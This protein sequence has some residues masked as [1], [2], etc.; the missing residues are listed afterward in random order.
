MKE[1]RVIVSNKTL[2]CPLRVIAPS[3]REA[4]WMV[5]KLLRSPEWEAQEEEMIKSGMDEYRARYHIKSIKERGDA[6]GQEPGV[7][8]VQL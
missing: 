8:I 3:Q 7:T 5:E 2:W 6:T 1:Y 4:E